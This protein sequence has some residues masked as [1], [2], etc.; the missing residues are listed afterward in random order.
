MI[1]LF[2]IGF[3]FFRPHAYQ[4]AGDII[5]DIQTAGFKIV[6]L[7]TFLLDFGK[8]DEFLEVYKGVLAHYGEVV[9]ELSSG[10][11][12]AMQIAGQVDNDN[13]EDVVKNF[14]QLCGP[15]DPRVAHTIRPGTLRAKYGE[16]E[17]RNSVHCTDLSEDG[18]LEVEYFFKVLQ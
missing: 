4:R 13:D 15:L 3:L 1:Y 12:L 16:T 8:A 11:C 18:P 7:E 5:H 10:P 2:Y 17:V 14:R 6:A 9:R